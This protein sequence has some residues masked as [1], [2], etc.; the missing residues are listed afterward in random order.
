MRRLLQNSLAAIPAGVALGLLLGGARGAAGE[1]LSLADAVRLAEAHSPALLEAAARG[2]AARQAAREARASRW[3]AL[4]ARQVALRTDSPADAF[5]L[6]LNQERFSF[7]AFT[8]GD[9]NDPEPVAHFTSELRATMPL[10]T[11]G[12]LR[13]GIRQADR[14]AAAAAAGSEHARGAVALAVASAYM[15]VLLAESAAGLAQQARDTMAR[16][17]GQAEDFFAAGMI[18]ESDLLQARVQLGRMEETLIT[19]RNRVRLARAGL[20]RVMGVEQERGFELDAD[21]A[22]VAG[23]ALDLEAA[24]ATALERRHDVRAASAQAEA[25]RLGVARARGEYLPEIGL[26]ARYGFDD[27]RLFGTHGESSMLSAQATWNLWNWGQTAARVSRSRH[28][29]SAARQAERA[30]RQQV[31]FEVRQA[32]LAVGEA[33]GRHA[34]ALQAVSSAERAAGILDDRFRQGVA[35][36]TDLLDAEILLDETRVREVQAR[37]DLQRAVRTFEFSIGSSPVPE[38]SR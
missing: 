22:E 17:V 18:V 2:D 26:A 35:R 16:H 30:H 25:A 19:A 34:V 21:L 13:A 6:Q 14:I 8:A 31:E 38:V 9:P 36:V 37:F 33:R 24:V 27:E 12:R 23:P 11:G 1:A 32:W 29:E 10:F 4:Q 15:D 28:E 3:P 7:A 5:G 20:N